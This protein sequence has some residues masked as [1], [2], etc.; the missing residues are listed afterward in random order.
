MSGF[1][2]L[3]SLE[4]GTSRPAGGYSDDPEFKTLQQDLLG[5]LST[6][7]RN[8][9]R[10]GTEVNH[11]GTKRDNARLRER[12][13]DLLEQSRDLCKEIGEGVKKLQTWEDLTVRSGVRPRTRG[14]AV[15]ELG[16][17]W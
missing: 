5:K 11:L 14:G 13:H 10:L 4:S 6:L 15:G 1:D 7:R 12:V 3:S 16:L 8:V 17:T 2:Q 9:A